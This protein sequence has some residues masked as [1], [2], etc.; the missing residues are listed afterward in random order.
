MLQ[1]YEPEMLEHSHRDELS[2]IFA[3]GY[4]R[5]LKQSAQIEPETGSI[6]LA[7]PE[8]TVLSVTSGVNNDS[9]LGGADEH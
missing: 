4:L 9:Y 2:R 8:E 5:L 6:S 1:N 7:V 3:R